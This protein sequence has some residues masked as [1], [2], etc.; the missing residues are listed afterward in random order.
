MLLSES[1]DLESFFSK[2]EDYDE[3]STF[4]LAETEDHFES[5]NIFVIQIVQQI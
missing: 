4:V 3:Q 5:E 2:Q 1:D